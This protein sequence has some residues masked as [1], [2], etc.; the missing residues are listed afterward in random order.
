MI[1]D[2]PDHGKVVADEDVGKVVV[3]LQLAQQVDHLSLH[4][5]VECRGRFVEDNHT[6]L[7]DHRAGNRDALALTAG[8]FVRVAIARLGIEPD[9]GQGGDRAPV[10]I[11]LVQ[12]RL[13]DEQT[14][15][16]DLADCLTRRERPKGILEDEL[17]LLAQGPH[18]PTVEAGDV[19][20]V[21]A[22]MTIAVEKP[23]QRAPKRRFPRAG[24]T[25]DTDRLALPELDGDAV[26]GPETLWTLRKKSAA[27]RKIDRDIASLQDDRRV[28]RR[29]LL[30]TL[31]FGIDQ[32]AGIGGSRSLEDL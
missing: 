28:F 5:P 11:R 27:D 32:H 29:R 31:R 16:D 14:F 6:R 10:S 15:G 26:D 19:G 9:F 18:L 24:L 3:G 30:A 13:V 7:E 17:H 20:L 4:G 8:K 21:E 25:N 22:V 1:R 2:G 12:R 23:E